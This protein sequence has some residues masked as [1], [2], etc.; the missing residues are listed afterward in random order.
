MALIGFGALFAA[1]PLDAVTDEVG[2][3][4]YS[5]RREGGWG[6]DQVI[7]R[8]G[9]CQLDFANRRFTRD[10]K[11]YALEPKVFA[12]L[13]QL[14]MRPGELLTRGELLD[15][16]WGHQ[17]VTP[18]TLNRVISLARRALS[19]DA[20]GP[21]LIQTVHGAG[22]RYVGP[23]E[24]AV[25]ERA[26][27]RARFG[28]P[29]SARLPARLQTL[30]GREHELSQIGELLLAGRSLTILGTGGMGKTQCALAFAHEQAERY[31]DGIW[32]FDLVPMR[33][34]DEWLRALAIA[35]SIAASG[36]RELLHKIAH[37]L[38]GRRAL[39]LVDNCDRLSS[40]MGELIVE[41]LRAT[42][43]LKVLATS[44]QQLS[45]VG[46]R[47]LR[48]PPLRL[49]AI[50]H[51]ADE[52]ELLEVAGTPAVSLLLARIRD[53]QTDLKLTAGNSPTI[54]DICERLDGMPLALELA[55]ARFALL[56]PDQVL[57]RLD[58]RFRFLSSAIAG[59]DHRHRNLV[60]LLE[61]SFGLLSPVEQR[62]LAWLSVFIQG[63]SADAAI[64]LATPFG[65][66]PETVI[67]L[68]T[69]LVGKSLVVVDQS[70]SPPRY[71]LLER[72][73]EFALSQLRIVGDESRA[74]DA[75]L[76]YVLHMAED[77]H[78]DMVSGR[79]RERIG[80]LMREH[81]N[82][83]AACEYAL[84]AGDDSPAAMR[85]V[86]LLMLYFKSHG[87]TAFGRRLCE[88]ALAGVSA[89]RTPERGL[90]L[91]CLGVNL[92]VGIKA[93]ADVPLLEAAS[94]SQ[95]AGD[96]WAAA[97]SSGYYALW[98]AHTGRTQEAPAHIAMTEHAAVQLVDGNLSGLAGLARGWMHL[99]VGNV[100][101][102]AC[103]SRPCRRY[104]I[105]AVTII[106]ITL[107][108]RTSGSAFFR[109]GD[110][111]LAAAQWLE[112]MRN[113]I[114]VGHARGVAGSVEGCAYI[115][116]RIGKADHACR[117]LRAAAEIRKRTEMPLFSFW[118]RHNEE[119]NAAL[120]SSLGRQR[121]EAAI[122]EGA[123]MRKEDVVNEA[124][125][126]LREF[127]VAATT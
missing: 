7:Y 52:T 100:G 4:A 61:W 21:K 23:I 109:R 49:P 103:H 113:G 8:C 93:G 50:R 101:L 63:W 64:D 59:R 17:Y 117:F 82:V 83:A 97:Y 14:F 43:Q 3:F 31:P 123:R 32:F 9:D 34:A 66:T 25:S 15:A 122:G 53:A 127:S 20:E 72:V 51:P 35:L 81:G 115:A 114:S 126:L 107:S 90:A 67:D 44:Q 110:L 5:R 71:R 62:F 79:M 56:S 77:A 16:V 121:Y 119:A 94:I 104:A 102:S 40:D 96:V 42:D 95:E 2:R 36:D 92:A 69:G 29:P 22:Y 24:T 124:A 125:A 11:E 58:Q 37:S 26:E 73:R 48:M 91:M 108:T 19:D 27:P 120:L 6:L 80:M 30:I 55:A 88:R 28:P 1:T 112:A 41:L 13:V 47:V 84:G 98:L 78:K 106:S 116:E 75:H 111:G 68:L 10:G 105:L 18:S 118:Y 99:A 57:E 85:I 38:A 74:R 65:S 33:A 12:V 46:E 89:V 54:T 87:E 70:L 76:A 39:L 45:F 60:A 86:G